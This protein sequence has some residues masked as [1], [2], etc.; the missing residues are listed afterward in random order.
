MLMFFFY[1]LNSLCAWFLLFS[2]ELVVGVYY[3]FSWE[4]NHFWRMKNFVS[5]WL[6]VDMPFDCIGTRSS[7][8]VIK[9]QKET[10]SLHCEGTSTYFPDICMHIPTIE[11][12]VSLIKMPKRWSTWSTKYRCCFG[13]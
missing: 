5:L 8:T 11:L 7:R 10:K 4:A 9:S 1:S 3:L 12:F 6:N 2:S 13:V